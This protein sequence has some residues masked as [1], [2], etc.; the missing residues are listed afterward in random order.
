MFSSSSINDVAQQLPEDHADRLA[1]HAEIHARP[2]EALSTP[3]RVSHWVMSCDDA[4][5]QQ[6]RSHLLELLRGFGVGPPPRS[7]THFRGDVGECRL[8]W[9]L[10]TEFV[11]WTF[12]WRAECSGSAVMAGL[13]SI[14]SEW[15]AALPGRRLAAAQLWACDATQSGADLMQTLFA[16]KGALVG[17]AVVNGAAEVLT[18]FRLHDDGHVRFLV[19]V[20]DMSAQQLGRLVQQVLEV[21]TYR[22]AALLGLPA[23]RTATA[24]LVD[25]ERELSELA[26]AIRDARR[27]E[28]FELLDRLTRLA[29]VVEGAYA[30]SHSRFSASKAY[31]D[32]VDRRLASMQ[33][34]PLAGLQTVGE[35][36]ERRLGP[37]RS[38]CEWVGRRQDALSERVSRVSSLL[39]TRVEIDQ[40]Q[41]SRSLLAAMN[42]RQ[43]L[44]LKIQSAVEGLSVA[45]ITYYIVGLILYAAKGG[46]HFGW[47]LEPELTAAAS[48]PL[49][50]LLV[51]LSIRRLHRH[52]LREDG[53]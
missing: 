5:R 17:S 27:E 15:L 22:M 13:P 49:V 35:F 51:W 21:D 19:R 6:S 14:P 30:G 45:A 9:E 8:R 53:H 31:F 46:K 16:D 52:I 34:R 44:Q 48:I 2:P 4:Q 3:L 7:A 47:P 32:L 12:A 29:G 11:T 36:I 38:T 24:V 20:R 1:L 43:G 26:Q 28:E 25:A 41:S 37:A 18:D 39:R 33:E 10:H 50:A 23:A 40:Q 42:R